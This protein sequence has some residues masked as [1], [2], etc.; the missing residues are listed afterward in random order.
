M[1]D[2]D[3]EELTVSLSVRVPAT[4]RDRLDACGTKW[5]PRSAVL[6]LAIEL[7]VERLEQD[8]DLIDRAEPRRPGPK[9]S[10]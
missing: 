3:E 9:P 7:G 6:R 2:G 8:P 5:M 1:A 4:L 10:K